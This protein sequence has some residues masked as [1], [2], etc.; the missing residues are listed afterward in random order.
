[1]QPVSLEL[2]SQRSEIIVCSMHHPG[3]Q[4]NPHKA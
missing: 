4:T 3:S 2:P 1:V